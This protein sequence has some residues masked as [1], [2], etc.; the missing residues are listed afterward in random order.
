MR[1]VVQ[2]FIRLSLVLL[3]V[4]LAPW[5]AHADYSPPS[6]YGYTKGASTPQAGVLIHS[7]VATLGG[8]FAWNASGGTAYLEAFDATSP[9]TTGTAPVWQS[10]S[11]A[12]NSFCSA[13]TVPAGGIKVSTGL[14]VAFS[15]TGPTYTQAA[16]SS[17]GTY[18][19]AWR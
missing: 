19:V 18:M 17:T 10:S 13:A 15:S 1:T 8:L 11:C 7:G 2:K 4:V 14:Y 12:V 3:L 5:P 6:P 9:P 16:G